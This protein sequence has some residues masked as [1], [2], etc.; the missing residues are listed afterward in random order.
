MLCITVIGYAR[1]DDEHYL[2][3]AGREVSLLVD[4]QSPTTKNIG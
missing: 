1:T 2:A 3:T 4:H